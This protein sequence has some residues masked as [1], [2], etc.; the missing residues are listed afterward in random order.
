MTFVV[1]ESST[2]ELCLRDFV[3]KRVLAGNITYFAAIRL[4]RSRLLSRATKIIRDANET[5]SDVW[6]GS[7]DVDEEGRTSCANF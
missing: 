4:F 3:Q 7:M 5:G 1:E 2:T 6:S